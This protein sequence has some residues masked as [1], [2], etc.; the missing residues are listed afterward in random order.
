MLNIHLPQILFNVVVE[1]G[2]FCP[3]EGEEGLADGGFDVGGDGAAA[4]VVLVVALAGE[5]ADEAVLDGTLQMM[6]HV[7]VHLFEAEGHTDRLVGAILGAIFSLHLWVSEIDTGNNKVIHGDIVLDDAT[8]A[9]FHKGAVV[10]LTDS[11]FCRHFSESLF[12][13]SLCIFG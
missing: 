12:L 6:G 8:K 3:A 5:K 11:T 4:V 10:A 13:H 1:D 2:G 9:M 7:V